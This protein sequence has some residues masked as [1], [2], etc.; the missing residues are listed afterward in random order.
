ME[1]EQQLSVDTPYFEV[2]SGFYR[3]YLLEDYT[4]QSCINCPKAHTIMHE[5]QSKMGDTLLCMAVHSGNYAVPSGTVFTADY[6]TEIG[7]AWATD[8]AVSNYPSG[9]INRQV[10]SNGKR[11]LAY[12]IWKNVLDTLTRTA[13][14]I[15]LQIKDTMVAASP[16]TAYVF[17]KVSCLKDFSR[18]LK[19][20]VVLL[21]DSIV[22][23]QLNGARI[24]TNYTHNHM[25]RTAVSPLQGS[26]LSSGGETVTA[27]TIL[28]RGYALYRQPVW[29][30]GHCSVLAFVCDA[31]TEEVLQ[32]ETFRCR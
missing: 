15:G 18:S 27:G 30:W 29:K 12:T 14:E 3:K 9:M 2:P 26:L 6:R 25:L 16:D 24:D 10:M 1:T 20:Y 32:A 4:G 8:F 22:S 7:N 19:L 28:I 21:E 11:V 5:L 13:P 31:E 17:V 23:P